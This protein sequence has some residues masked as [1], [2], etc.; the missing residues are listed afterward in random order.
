MPADIL[1][2]RTLFVDNITP[3]EIKAPRGGRTF[4][5]LENHDA[6]KIFF[7]TDMIAVT[8]FASELQPVANQFSIRE[9]NGAS[10]PQGSIWILGSVAGPQRVTVAQRGK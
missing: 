9:W 4:L 8:A 6:A 5:S 1:D 2:R 7:D 3:L 10:C